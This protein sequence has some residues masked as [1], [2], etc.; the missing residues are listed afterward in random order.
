MI[1]VWVESVPG[2]GSTVWGCSACSRGS[3]CATY[4][5]AVTEAQEHSKYHDLGRVV[6]IG[7]R[8]G[9]QPSDKRDAKVRKL[10][11]AGMSLRSIGAIVKLSHTAVSNSLR[12]TS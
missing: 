9:P 11:D 3:W 10:R 2:P 7:V 8:R 12:R 1:D 6:L 4:E 5:G